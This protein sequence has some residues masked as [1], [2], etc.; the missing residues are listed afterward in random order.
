MG[1]RKVPK[2]PDAPKKPTRPFIYFMMSVGRELRKEM[3]KNPDY[4][5][6]EVHREC[7][8]RWSALP[9]EEKEKYQEMFRKDTTRYQE[10]MKSYTPS[11]EYLEKVRLAKQHKTTASITI[12]QNRK[13]GSVPY[14][15]KAYFEYMANTWASVAAAHPRLDPGQVQEE[16][17]RRWSQGE[18]EDGDGCSGASAWDENKNFRKKPRKKRIRK[19][20][21]VKKNDPEP[22]RTAYQCF[23]DTMKGE[24]RKHLPD[25]SYNDLQKHVAA[26][27]KVM[28][29]VEKEPFFELEKK[30]KEKYEIQSQKK[31]IVVECKEEGMEENSSYV[32]VNTEV[33]EVDGQLMEQQ[34]SVKV[35]LD[36]SDSS[37]DDYDEKPFKDDKAGVITNKSASKNSQVDLDLSNISDS[38]EFK[39]VKGSSHGSNGTNLIS[40]SSSSSSSEGSSDSD[41]D[42]DES[43]DD[44]A[45]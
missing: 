37:D 24:L 44:F 30:E 39:A 33:R 7:G 15:T 36:A 16:V 8:R 10:A 17:W 3:C 14:M 25:M 20:I 45:G 11:A 18:P 40:S 2:D 5:K 43:E 38:K 31:Q 41:D 12:D 9:E 27:W 1:N 42:S 34:E 4:S 28:T 6:A 29:D 22:P 13:F 19:R 23:L 26:K 35:D 32:E 21:N